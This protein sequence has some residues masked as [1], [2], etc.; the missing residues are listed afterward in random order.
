[1]KILTSGLLFCG[2]VISS[3]LCSAAPK[4]KTFSY[5]PAQVFEAALSAAREHHVVSFVDEKHL[6]F[7]FETGKSLSSYG[8]KCD[9]AVE[10]VNS[11]KSAEMVMNTQTKSEKQLIS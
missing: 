10:A 4:K 5:A 6:M 2:V 11:G 9:V 8:N 1:M 7:T 3:T